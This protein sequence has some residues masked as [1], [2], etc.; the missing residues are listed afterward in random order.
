LREKD[1]IASIQQIAEV[2]GATDNSAK[3]TL[4]SVLVTANSKFT[5]SVSRVSHFRIERYFYRI[6]RYPSGVVKGASTRNPP[7]L[8]L[9]TPD[10]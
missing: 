9:K 3:V 5:K 1:G 6:E 4:N 7:T 2:V 10:L 8:F